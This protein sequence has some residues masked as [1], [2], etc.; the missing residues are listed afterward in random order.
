L[1]SNAE[2]QQEHKKITQKAIEEN[3]TEIRIVLIIPIFFLNIIILI[4]ILL[5]KNG[6]SKQ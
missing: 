3:K 2:E 6:G 5:W 1:L 4:S